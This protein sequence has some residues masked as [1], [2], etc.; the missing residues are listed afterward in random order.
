MQHLREDNLNIVH[1]SQL[2][3]L[4]TNRKWQIFAF[5]AIVGCAAIAAVPH[6]A[7]QALSKT[8]RVPDDV[9]NPI[10]L[11]AWRV[12]ASTNVEAQVVES[13]G[14]RK[15]PVRLAYSAP[16]AGKVDAVS[17]GGQG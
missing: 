14:G 13:F 5:V 16:A 15:F 10:S 6:P 7:L 11:R 4:F 8:E 12:T 9:A 2:P 17:A 3:Q 1:K